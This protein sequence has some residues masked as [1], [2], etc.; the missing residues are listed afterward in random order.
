M[1]PNKRITSEQAKQDSYFQ[2]D[3]TP[4]SEYII[5]NFMHE[6][7]VKM[8][9]FFLSVFAGCPIPYPKREFLTDDDQDDKDKRQQ[10][11]NVCFIYFLMNS[12]TFLFVVFVTNLSY[13]KYLR[14]I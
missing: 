3:P 4:T 7:K 12:S 2:E 1:D 9:S 8:F 6:N 11:T 5:I 13:N 14:S 10:A